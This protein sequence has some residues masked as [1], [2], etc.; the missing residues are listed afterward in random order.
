MLRAT[1]IRQG[2]RLRRSAYASTKFA[3]YGQMF[4]YRMKT[5]LNDKF[6]KEAGLDN[7]ATFDV[8][9]TT[10]KTDYGLH[11]I[12]AL[13]ESAVKE[14]KVKEQKTENTAWEGIEEGD[15]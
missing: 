12:G 1:W 3:L 2:K 10:L 15:E 7:P 9:C 8:V 5:P 6:I 4:R 13:G 11:V 14:K